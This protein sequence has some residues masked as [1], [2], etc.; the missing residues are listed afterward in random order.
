M[1]YGKRALFEDQ[2]SKTAAQIVVS[3]ATYLRVGS[4]FEHPV[5]MLMVQ[6]LTD[7][8][9]QFSV[10]DGSAAAANVPDSFP[11]LANTSVIFDYTSNAVDDWPFFFAKGDAVWVKELGVPAS[12][13]VYVSVVYGKGD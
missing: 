7:V 9:L 8:S 5:R 4:A 2:R 12:G 13:G 10:S 11:L 3:G 6:N 1:G